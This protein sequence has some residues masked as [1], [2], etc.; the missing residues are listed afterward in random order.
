MMP[1]LAYALQIMTA[2]PALLQAGLDVKDLIESTRDRM[3]EMHDEN[4]DP[5]DADWAELNEKIDAL[6]AQLHS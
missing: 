5:N 1:A 6:R 2:L 4:R 3:K